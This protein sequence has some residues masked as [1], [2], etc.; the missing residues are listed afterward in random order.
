MKEVLRLFKAV[1][2]KEKKTKNPSKELLKF[3]LSKRF[4]FSPE[5]VYNYSEK[6]LFKIADIVEKELG[7][8]A[9]QANSSF[10]KSW[11]KIKEASIEQLVI[12]Q[13]I[14]YITTYGFEKL[15]IYD[16]D[17]VYIPRERLAIPLLEE[18]V[19]VMVIKGY[20]KEELKDKLLFLLKSGIAL[21][22]KTIE[23]IMVI[24]D[25]VKIQEKEIDEIK[26]KE[27]RVRLY[28]HLDLFPENSI[29]FLRFCVY[30]ATDKT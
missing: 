17:Y 13:I 11:K 18:D 4:I 6:E 20:T 24:V 14:H 27:V 8:T 19:S 23:D 3:T 21:N 25:S 12:E 5:V 2:I 1:E 30:K 16:K 9:Q 10:H 29:E 26:N 28:D 15:G 7:L 22:E